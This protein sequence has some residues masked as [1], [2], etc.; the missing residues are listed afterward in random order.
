MTLIGKA[1]GR[2]GRQI[3]GRLELGALLLPRRKPVREAREQDLGRA[4]DD[5]AIVAVDEDLL[6]FL[7]AVANVGQASHDRHAHGP[8]DDSHV[9]GQRAFFQ[10]HALQAAA[11]VFQ[12]LGRP[13]IARDENRVVREAGLRRRPDPARDDPQQPVRQILEVVHAI[14]EQRIVDILHP[15][16]RAL[17]DPLDRRLGGEAAVDRLVDAPRPALVIGEHLVGLEDLLML[18]GGAEL[19][20][21][22]HRVD[23]LAHLAEGGIDAVA[24]GLDVLGDRM[25]DDDSRLV[26]HRFA[27]TP[28]PRPA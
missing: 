22:G 20:L 17:L 5:A 23:L 13:E 26:E 11:V 28:F 9:R 18:A 14:L 24:F 12:Q 19:G 25:L 27:A 3:A 15:R 10:H 6:A 21:L 1:V 8:C 2:D 7:D 16:A 4:D